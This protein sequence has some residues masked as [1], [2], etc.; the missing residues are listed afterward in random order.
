MKQVSLLA[1]LLILLQ[2]GTAGAQKANDHIHT[3]NTGPKMATTQKNKTV[4][5]DLYERSLNAHDLDLLEDYISGSFTGVRGTRGAAAFGAPIRSLI[6]A[7]PDIRWTIGTMTAEDERVTV[8]WTWTGTHTGDFNGFP[9]TGKKLTNDGMAIYELKDG[10]VINAAVQTDRLG[11]LQEMQ[12]IPRDLTLLPGNKGSK[13]QVSF[14]DKFF[15]PATA[16]QEFYE[17]MQI[18]RGFIR[19]L[20][21]FIDDAA[22]EYE[23]ENGNLVCVTVALWQSRGALDKAKEA[24]QAEYRKQGFDAAEMFKRLHITADRGIYTELINR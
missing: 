1:C 12:A 6:E 16:K 10:K 4:I 7:F 8:S 19:T 15:V 24:V 20:P 17:R 18:N 13:D 9:A 14:I 3:Q 11:F 5:R 22:Y 2:P 21:G 23:D